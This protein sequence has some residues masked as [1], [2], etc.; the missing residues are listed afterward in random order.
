MRPVSRRIARAATLALLLG[1]TFL[2]MAPNLTSPM[3]DRDSGVFLY[4]GS[5]ILRGQ[6]PYLDTW[7]HKGP[8]MYFLNAGAVALDPGGERGLWA[9]EFAALLAAG[10]LLLAAGKSLGRFAAALAAI[11]FYAG[12]IL[13][14]RPG[15]FTEEFALPLAALALL[16]VQ[17]ERALLG[18]AAGFALGACLAGSLLLRPNL[19]GIPLLAALAL[20]WMGR[21]TRRGFRS[22]AV[23]IGAG[24]VVLAGPILVYLA[25]HGALADAWDQYFLFNLVYA[26]SGST[27][28]WRVVV[29]GLTILLPS[30]LPIAGL[31]GAAL[32]GKDLV[33]GRRAAPVF[34]VAAFDLPLEIGLTALGWA[35]SDALLSDMGSLPGSSRR[36][37]CGQARLRRVGPR[38]GNRVSEE[39]GGRCRPGPPGARDAGAVGPLQRGPPVAGGPSIRRA[40]GSFAAG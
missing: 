36:L 37:A 17:R 39:D 24:M 21:S 32:I 10:G 13:T 7:D 28:G 1:L 16:V 9:L 6:V 35:R 8:L 22:A 12:V 26:G 14:L 38:T 30:G 5:Q 31:L 20:L 15:N 2:A 18:R 3:P 25:A 23:G 4:I 29:E 33:R 40:C 11:W 27:A 34:L 19:V